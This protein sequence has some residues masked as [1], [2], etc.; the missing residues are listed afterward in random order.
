MVSVEKHLNLE[1][2]ANVRAN[3]VLFDLPPEPTNKRGRPRKK[4]TG[5]I[6]TISSNSVLQR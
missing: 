1:L 5:L 6:F 2:I 4:V 3:S